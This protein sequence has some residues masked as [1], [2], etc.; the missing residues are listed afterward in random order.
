MNTNGL[1]WCCRTFFISTRI[2]VPA[3]S[4]GRIRHSFRPDLQLVQNIILD[5]TPLSWVSV[6]RVLLTV[7]SWST[8]AASNREPKRTALLFLGQAEWPIS[9]GECGSSARKCERSKLLGNN[10]A[11]FWTMAMEIVNH[12][13]RGLRQMRNLRTR[14]CGVV[15]VVI[16]VALLLMWVLARP[17]HR[18]CLSPPY[19]WM[20]NCSSVCSSGDG[21]VARLVHFV[22]VGDTFG[23][24]QWVAV[25][26]AIKFIQPQ[27]VLLF[28]T[29]NLT[30]CWASR[31]ASHSLVEM[32]HVP[33]YAIPQSMNGVDITEAAHKA[34]FLRLSALW[35]FG[36]I[37]MDTDAIATKSFH[38]F[39]SKEAVLA[40]QKGGR[41]GNGLMVARQKSCFICSFAK[42]ACSEF[43]GSWARHSV[44]TLYRMLSE[45]PTRAKIEFPFVVVL[46][47][48]SGFF[49]FDHNSDGLQQLFEDSTVSFNE[50]QVFAIHLFQ[51]A[52]SKLGLTRLITFK[53]IMNSHT[54]VARVIRRVLP[55]GFREV[56]MDEQLC[57]PMPHVKPRWLIWLQ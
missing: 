37:Y 42:E 28:T 13:F 19:P 50:T 46:P 47:H 57:K 4:F 21:P 22:Q 36:G 48:A 15:I 10:A 18:E 2:V 26:S 1:F 53:W 40:K 11:S 39:F 25:M 24:L 5:I 3:L 33:S 29:T 9:I 27:R 52:A 34:D 35:Q 49:P 23:F 45:N 51:T 20:E 17:H 31:L 56:D 8:S 54:V 30:G 12:C 32:K 14:A 6:E 43:D 38:P 16:L 55:L 41:V 44:K 7:S